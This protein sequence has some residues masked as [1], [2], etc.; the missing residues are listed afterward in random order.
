Y[1]VYNMQEMRLLLEIELPPGVEYCTNIP[2]F[3][4]TQTKDNRSSS[5]GVGLRF[6]DDDQAARFSRDIQ[7]FR[8]NRENKKKTGQ[9]LSAIYVPIQENGSES[10][11]FLYRIF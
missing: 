6:H 11:I 7:E 9:L 1:K 3:H 5:K 10:T 2:F 8:R 4:T